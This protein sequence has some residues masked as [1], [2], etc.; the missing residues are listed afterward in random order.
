MVAALKAL[1]TEVV[2]IEVPGGNHSSVVQPNLA[3][4]IEFF[5]KHKKP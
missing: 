5:G 2:Y 4:M 3:G 1:N